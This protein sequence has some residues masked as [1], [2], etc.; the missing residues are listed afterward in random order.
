M[1]N[2]RLFEEM[3]CGCNFYLKVTCETRRSGIELNFKM[4]WR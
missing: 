3:I 4:S 2:S 1:I